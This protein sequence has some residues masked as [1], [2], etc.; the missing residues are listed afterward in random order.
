M[1]SKHANLQRKAINDLIKELQKDSIE[2]DDE[3]GRKVVRMVLHLLEDKRIGS[4]VEKSAVKC[5]RS[6]VNEVKENQ[7]ETI[8]DSLLLAYSNGVE[9]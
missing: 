4:K 8:V 3:P 2:L 5:L 9:Q 7:V 1:E 6:L